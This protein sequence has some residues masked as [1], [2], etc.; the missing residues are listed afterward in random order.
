MSH[1]N[2]DKPSATNDICQPKVRYS[3]GTSNGA[4]M[5][6]MFEPALKM[7]VATERSF[8]GNHSATVLIAVGKLP[9]SPSPSAKRA[10]PKPN[11]DRASA[12]AIAARLHSTME[13]ALALF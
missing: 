13:N 1:T 8:G 10:V 4:K 2:P 3:H 5:A 9:D 7:P 11:T 6:P 12:C